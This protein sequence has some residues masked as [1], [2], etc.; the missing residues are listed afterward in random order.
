MEPHLCMLKEEGAPS[1]PGCTYTVGYSGVH[2]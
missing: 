2:V 1:S